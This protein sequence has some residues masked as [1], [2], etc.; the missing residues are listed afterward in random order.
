MIMSLQALKIFACMF[1]L[2]GDGAVIDKNEKV[3]PF[4]RAI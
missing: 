2:V 1:R 4:N 3:N